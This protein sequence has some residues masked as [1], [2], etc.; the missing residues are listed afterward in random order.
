MPSIPNPTPIRTAVALNLGA[1]IRDLRDR[2]GLSQSELAE[3]IGVT[4]ATIS[5][6]ESG[7]RAAGIDDLVVLAGVLE[8][9]VGSLFNALEA[10]AALDDGSDRRERRALLRA[11]TAGAA[12][13]Y[14]ADDIDEFAAHFDGTT[15]PTAVFEPRGR[16]TPRM[17]APQLL[18]HLGITTP[19]V[20]L[21]PLVKACGARMRSWAFSGDVS[22]VLLDLDGPV[23]GYNDDH[24]YTRRRFTIAHELGHYLLNHHERF[25]VDLRA[26][27]SS[28]SE[29]PGFKYEVERDAN[30]FAAEILMPVRM[31]TEAHQTTRDVSTLASTFEVSREAMGFRLVNLRLARK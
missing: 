10:G 30:Q 31:V 15:P 19:P 28:Q 16:R 12:L 24:P 14:L 26:P 7:R 2:R 27:V 4:Q 22:G 8:V 6:W 9:S 17:L 18:E 1:R 21:A 29:P 25:H 3:R 11:A 20:R 23:I 5:A 13:E